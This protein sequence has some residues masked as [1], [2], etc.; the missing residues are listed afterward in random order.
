MSNG[1]VAII[2]ALIG[3]VIG[4]V[5]TQILADYLLRR[6]ERRQ[7]ESDLIRSHLFQ[8]ED[9]ALSLLH[10]LRNVM[11]QEGRRKIENRSDGKAYY[12]TST[13]Y[14]LGSFLAHKRL[15]LLHGN[16]AVLDDLYPGEGA[17][18]RDRLET[19]ERHLD[20][21]AEG[22]EFFRQD[23]LALAESVM[24]WNSNGLRICSSLEFRE[25]YEDRKQTLIRRARKQTLIR[26][27]LQPA[28]KF[29]LNSLEKEAENLI[30]DLEVITKQLGNLRTGGGIEVG[31]QS[32]PDGYQALDL[33]YKR[34]G[35]SYEAITEFRA[36]LLALLPLATG[37]AVFLLL[38]RAQADGPRFRQLLGPI[39]IFSAVVTLGLFTYE[40][41]GM[42]RCHRLEV[43]AGTLER[44]LGLTAELGPFL[45][46]PP[47]ALGNMLGP[48]AAGLIIYLATVFA[49]LGLAGFGFGWWKRVSDAWGL[50]LVYGVVLIGAWL[51]LSWW[52]RRSATGGL[53]ADRRNA[54]L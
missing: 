17:R 34:A 54:K 48:P 50:L 13:L 6:R 12:V 2:A 51:G 41:R 43:Q 7:R 19:M 20:P 8:L 18:L 14:L 23:R 4:S 1:M 5:G 44:Q 22:E 46:Q 42:Q 21:Q 26:H 49:W 27:A 10:R 45:G 52:L 40:L 15:L 16:Y 35:D 9:A 36:K 28:E 39:G 47:R 38:E 3:A 37:T 31:D 32:D 33:A 25:A 11:Y 24:R 29:V 53:P 30:N